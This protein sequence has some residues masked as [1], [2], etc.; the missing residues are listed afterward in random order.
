MSPLA[1]LL[2]AISVFGVVRAKDPVDC[3][4]PPAGWP[5]QP[6][7]CCDQ[8]YP[9]DQ[10]R[11]HL[12][13]CIRQY[14]APSSAVLTEK[15]VRERRSCVEE[16]VYRSAGF[17]NKEDSVLQREA[18]EKQLQSISGDSWK[19]A[20]SESLNACF[21]EAEEIEDSLSA[22]SSVEEESSCSSIPERLT[23]CLSRQLFLNCP[24]DT[25]KNSQEC[26]VVKNRM[27]ECK[28]LLP[29]PP[30][31]FIRPGPRPPI[32]DQ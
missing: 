28:Q 27:E 19:N 14:G 10:M 23:F 3:S 15:S 6:P 1:A 24:E 12:V 9:T 29:P 26:Q 8:P 32:V 20:I 13:G 31:R 5:R 22:S 16:C 18:I 30:I 21:K 7:N 25:W 2:L 17:I 4:K 11:K